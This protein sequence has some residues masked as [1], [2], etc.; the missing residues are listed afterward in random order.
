MPGQRNIHS[1]LIPQRNPLGVFG[2]DKKT[3]RKIVSM[4]TLTEEQVAYLEQKGARDGRARVAALDQE[5]IDQVVVIPGMLMFGDLQLVRN[6]EAAALIARA[7]NDWAHDWCSVAPD[8]L[9]PGA[10]LPLHD[11]T[12]A[13]GEVRRVAKKGFKLAMVRPA[14]A[15]GRYPNQPV[16]DPL[17]D[18]FEETGLVVA[19][20]TFTNH[21]FSRSEW[22][23]QWAPAE[24]TQCVINPRQL[25]D[26]S[27]T[28]SFIHE[29]MTWLP[30]VLL[31]DFFDRH[32]GIK[33]MAV[34]ESNATWLPMVLEELDRAFHLFRNERSHQV[35]RLPSEFFFE[36]CLIAFEGDE[37]P[38]YRQY[39]YF[40][41]IGIW[42]SDLYRHDGADAW[43]A[44]REME[45]AEVPESVRAK[46]MGGN[47][48]RMY[49]IEPKLF[50]TEEPP[51]PQRPDWYPKPEEV[52]QEYA[53]LVFR[54]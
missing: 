16:F 42:S 23:S 8:R 39:P 30:N 52:E 37:T 32:P 21:H 19:M 13:A 31:T 22:A 28:L 49:G 54:G 20:H 38:V 17:W 46:L 48:H 7:Y 51:P 47:A 3:M 18:A 6:I 41:D 1:G 29:A 53:H 35:S 2:V 36:R 45:D 4:D 15:Q 44:L 11:A 25:P 10:P 14:D 40:Q 5:G 33:A 34:M 26:A 27:E 9:F 12:R 50:V 24:F 43:V